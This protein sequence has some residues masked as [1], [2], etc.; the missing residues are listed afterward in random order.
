MFA[1]FNRSPSIFDLHGDHY[2][3]AM[4]LY[5][6]LRIINHPIKVLSY[7]IHTE[8]EDVWPNRKSDIFQ[9]PKN[10][11]T[12]H[13][14][15]VYGNKEAVSAK[16]NAISAFSSQSPSADNCFLYSFAKQNELFL[17]ESIQ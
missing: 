13:W 8:N 14:I 2:A 12:F 15:Y 5:D 17:L 16:R 1:E 7:L 6:A 10:L 4:Y 11:T 9:P 3:C